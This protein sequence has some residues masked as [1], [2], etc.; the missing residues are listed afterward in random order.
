MYMR[1]C[2]CMRVCVYV[3]MYLCL[4]VFTRVRAY[5]R[6][7]RRGTYSSIRLNLI[8]DVCASL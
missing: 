4:Y 7:R 5:V 3:C 8:F 2:L 6:V 1:L